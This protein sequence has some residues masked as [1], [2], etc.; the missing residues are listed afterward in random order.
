MSKKTEK[1]KFIKM[2]GAGNDFIVIPTL[3]DADVKAVRKFLSKTPREEFAVKAC[4]RFLG[5]GADG[6]LFLEKP[7][8]KKTTVQWD[9]YNS[10]GSRP[11]MCANASRCVMRYLA[12]EKVAKGKSFKIQ[13]PFGIVSGHKTKDLVT[14]QI[15][16][17]NILDLKKKILIGNE[18]VEGG[19]IDSGV[20]HFVVWAR[21]VHDNNGRVEKA[22]MIRNHPYFHPRGT[23]ATF[24]EEINKNELKAISFERGVE[25][26]TLAC[27]TG[28]VA[29]A[30][31]YAHV[32]NAKDPVKIHM[33]GGTLIVEQKAGFIELTGPATRVYD[34]TMTHEVLD[35]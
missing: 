6:L 10:D 25:N 1:I 30:V 27:G 11:E 32:K 7:K 15:A 16:N 12:E 26:F 17:V 21:N 5:V 9:F 29:A 14:I 22:K 34:G 13:T 4:N 2:S 20:P 24:I 3:K 19:W 33:P 35:G 18:N 31:Y 23:N 28:A 8:D